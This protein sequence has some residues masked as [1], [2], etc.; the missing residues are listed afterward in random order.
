MKPFLSTV[1]LSYKTLNLSFRYILHTSLDKQSSTTLKLIAHQFFFF[2]NYIVLIAEFV[3]HTGSV[4]MYLVVQ[5]QPSLFAKMHGEY[6]QAPVANS[7]RD[8][9]TASRWRDSGYGC[10]LRR[11]QEVKAFSLAGFHGLLVFARPRV[12][13]LDGVQS[14]E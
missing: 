3:F 1:A 14:R 2:C 10:R 9:T 4:Y 5:Q 8:A 6:T 7:R 11:S 13:N 12:Y